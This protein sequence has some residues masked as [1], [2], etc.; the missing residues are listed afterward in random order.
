MKTASL[1]FSVLLIAFYLTACQKEIAFSPNNP[2]NPNPVTTAVTGNLKAKFD[3]VQWTAT[4]GAAASRIQGLINITGISA[5][6][7]LLTITLTDSGVHRYTLSDM[8]ISVAALI[9]STDPNPYSFTSNQGTYPSTSGGEVNITSIDTAKK[10]ISGNFTFKVYRDIDNKGKTVTEGSFTNLSYTTI[11]PSSAASDTFRVKISGASWSPASING[12]AIPIMNQI[13]INGTD[14][15]G[16][17]AVG[18]TFPSNITPG[19]YTLDLFGATYIGQYNPDN[20]PMHSKGSVSGTLTILEHNLTTKRI[21]GTFD[22]RGEE[23]LHPTNFALITEG[24]FSVK[25][26]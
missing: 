17:K 9:D 5:D 15:T 7:K 3:G 8:T 21:R 11:L 12:F 1:I 4:K 25:Y 19:A 2:A 24:Y 13:G 26:Q 18:L 22:F 10:T 20:D 16:V 14:A 6:R 23:L